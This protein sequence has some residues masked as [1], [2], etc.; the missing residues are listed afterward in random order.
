M[1]TKAILLL[2]MLM[3]AGKSKLLAQFNADSL[4]QELNKLWERSDLPGFAVSL[5]SAQGTIYEQGFGYADKQ[6]KTPFTPE[7]IINL[8]SVSKTVLGV[9]VIKAVE[10]GSLTMDSEINEFLPFEIKNPYFPTIPILVRHLITHSSTI[11]DT[12]HYSK[13]YISL[14]EGMDMEGDSVSTD[15][16]RFLNEHQKINLR[17]FVQS[18]LT[19]DGSWYKQRNFLHKKP[20][21]MVHYSNLN[22]SVTAL[23]LENSTFYPFKAFTEQRIFDTLGMYSSGWSVDEID[24]SKYATLYFPNGKT[25]PRYQLITYPDGGLLSSVHDL[26]KFLTEMIIVFNGTSGF[27]NDKYAE[28]LFPGDGDLDRSFWG[29]SGSEY[30]GERG[31]DPG[32]QSDIQ[33][34]R[35]SKIGRVIL[36]NVNADEDEI[37]YRDYR[38]IH[39]ILTR[40][41][42][43]ISEKN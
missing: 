17:D 25:L 9:A 34:N 14:F 3:L 23:V 31:S 30:I 29:M 26:S 19:T 18:I 2:S 37:L 35:T 15:F 21:S 40:Y 22:A 42:A 8:G 27:L 38:E 7:T 5:V 1:S 16:Q 33:F 36:C 11:L 24:M 13:S 4:T 32:I 39:Q 10:D 43:Q 41:E 20:G 6:F 12:R 28:L